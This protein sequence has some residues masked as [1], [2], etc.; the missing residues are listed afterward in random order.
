MD[1][2]NHSLHT[3]QLLV[4][5]AALGLA[6]IKFPALFGIEITSAMESF[7]VCVGAFAVG[8]MKVFRLV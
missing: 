5:G 4:C 6:I 8:V 1:H 2:R 7:G 3:A